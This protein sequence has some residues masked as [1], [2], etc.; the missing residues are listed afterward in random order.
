MTRS[1]TRLRS[2]VCS[3]EVIIIR[4][5]AEDV[6]LT[7]GGHAMVDLDA[8]RATVPAKEGLTDG[9][10]IGKRYIDESGALE[11]LVTKPGTGTLGIGTSPL[12]LKNAK[13]L[14]ASD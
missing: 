10:Q 1:G 14:P 12:V 3:T 13:P 4:A 7:C 5:G 6:E 8:S 9:A 2:Q 11:V